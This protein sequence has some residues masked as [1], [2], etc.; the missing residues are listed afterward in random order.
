MI[1]TTGFNPIPEIVDRARTLAERTGC[2]YAPRAKLSM[3][4]LVD[5]YGDEQVLVVL[6]EAV[7]LITPEMPP[8]EFHPSMGFVRAKRIIRGESDPLI[9]A[10]GMLPGDSVLDCTA[11]LGETPCCL[12]S[13]VG[14]IPGL[15]HWRAH[16]R[17]TRCC[18]RG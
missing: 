18:W 17:Y 10:A 4:K 15:R 11:G 5:Q 7:R 2:L 8:M 9:D 16:C 13:L 1:I 12:P 3:A 14:S 6:Q